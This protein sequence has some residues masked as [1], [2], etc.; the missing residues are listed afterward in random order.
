MP[1]AQRY[2]LKL[3][4]LKFLSLVDTP[5]QQT[6]N[7]RLIKR[8]GA[9]EEEIQ[10]TFKIAK[11]GS[12]DNP[13]VHGWAF[14]C[15]DSN[16]QPYHDLQGDAITEDFVKAAEEW[17]ASGGAV[18]EMHNEEQ[19]AKIAFAYPLDS[20]VITALIGK[21]AGAAT[22]ISG[23]AAAVRPTAEQLTK[24][25]SGDYTGFSI[26]GTGV[27]EAIKSVLTAADVVKQFSERGR[28]A[29]EGLIREITKAKKKPRRKRPEMPDSAATPYKRVGKIAVLTS[30][31]D[32]HQHTIDLEDPACSYSD[33]LS[34]SYQTSEG[35]TEGHSHA[36]VYDGTTGVITIALDSGHTH[37][38]TAVVPA[39][40]IAAAA[41]P[42]DESDAIPTPCCEEPKPAPTVVVEVTSC[43]PGVSTH[44]TPA[45]TVKHEIKEPTAMADPDKIADLEKSNSRL[46]KMTT[47]TD[48]QRAHF[49]K[50]S[51][52]EAEG[53]LNKSSHERDIVLSDIEKA[54]EV[55][56]TSPI[57]GA[58]YRKNDDRRLIEMA[59]RTDEAVTAQ[60]KAE[61][62]KRD[63]EFAKK[64]DEVLKHFPRGAKNNYRGRII[65]ALNAEFTDPAEYEEVMTGLKAHT[66]ARD[67]LG[68]AIGHNG[69]GMGP[70]ASAPEQK[71]RAA[72]EKYQADHKLPSYEIALLKATESDT[73]IRKL[74]DEAS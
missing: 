19:T 69:S 42:D 29:F 32:G 49:S 2:R 72:V 70:E 41:A 44:P 33:S 28:E 51:G 50:L 16:G 38:V 53:Y 73:N 59:K 1:P 9:S 12:G 7:F 36:W 46:E 65:K 3:T 18:D 66:E 57:D 67:Y 34:T 52:S 15:T 30:I 61:V 20:D 58:V 4:S 21:E 60:R 71:L 5:A 31:V 10:A 25:R 68:K 47:L 26:A 74:Y 48:A 17:L 56:Y 37:E 62:E 23:L 35:A 24:I 63:V 64:G 27:R 13:L 40:V 8:A 11:V 39:D 55:V 6:A 22:K 54:N 45:P 43:A 14:T